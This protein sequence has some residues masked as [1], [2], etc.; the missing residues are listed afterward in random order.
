MS[1]VVVGKI[2]ALSDFHLPGDCG[3]T[4]D[5]FGPIWKDHQ[6]TILNN[7]KN[8]CTENDILLSPGDISWADKIN[9]MKS[10]LELLSQFPC[11]V[12]LSQGNHDRWASK[13]KEV[14]EALPN[15]VVWALRGVHTFGN[16]AIVSQ[17]LWDFEGIFPWP[18][19]YPSKPISEKTAPREK[20]RLEKQLEL[21]PQDP[22]IIRI[23]MVHFPPVSY[24]GSPTVLTELINKYN[25][26]Y[27][28]YGHV[29]G[30][31]PDPNFKAADCTI[32][33][34][35]FILA[36]CDWLNMQPIEVCTYKP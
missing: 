26:D 21:L 27:C 13:Y 5:M 33:C 25:V 36:S 28:I 1:E 24:D 32:G 18:G 34:T 10:D 7:V 6:T 30:Q 8:C 14:I 20:A 35:R 19:H 12:I 15:N 9:Q 4:M 29:H 2:F 31:K 22:N 23:L 11:R 3:K 16:V 17:R